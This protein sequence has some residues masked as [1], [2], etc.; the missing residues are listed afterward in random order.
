[1]IFVYDGLDKSGQIQNGK[2]EASN[3]AEA[4]IKIKAQGITP[5]DV[6]ESRMEFINDLGFFSFNKISDKKLARLS[7]DLSIFLKS[8][9]S[10]AKAIKLSRLQY[11]K[12]RK[13]EQFL[14]SVENS[15]NEGKSF[16]LAIDTQKVIFLAEFFKQSIKVAENRGFLGDILGE[17][18]KFLSEKEKIKSQ[19]QAAFA[20]P[21][22]IVFASILMLIFMFVVAI[23]KMAEVFASLNQEL[24]KVTKIVLFISTFLGNNITAI[25]ISTLVLLVSIQLIY[26]KYEAFRIGFD[27]SMLKLPLF[28]RIIQTAELSRFLSVSAL[29][30][31]SYKLSN[32]QMT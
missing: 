4:K 27:F 22:F 31:H 19:V 26:K 17:L 7:R 23:P 15:L 30:C 13:L 6:K 20:Y 25:L 10:I 9:V 21:A 18:A 3:I 16:Y 2:I 11:K 32:T 5:Y 1:M 29:V 12:D 8:G 28:G 14:A 24:P